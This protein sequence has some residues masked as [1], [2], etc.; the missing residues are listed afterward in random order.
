MSLKMESFVLDH[1]GIISTMYQELG[2]DKIIDE[3]LGVHGN[4]IVSSGQAVLSIICNMLNILQKPI[5]LTPQFMS[6]RSIDRLLEPRFAAHHFNDDLIGH[7]LDRLFDFGLEELFLKIASAAFSKYSEFLSDYLHADTTTIEVYGDYPEPGDGTI[8]LLRGFNKRRRGDFKQFVLELVTCNRLPVFLTTAD[9]N[10]S[11][12]VVFRNLLKQYGKQIH[13]VFTDDQK[14]FIFDSKFYVE[15]TIVNVSDSIFWI[16]RVPE[17]V[18]QAAKLVGDLSTDQFTACESEAL[19]GYSYYKSFSCFAETAQQWVVVFSQ[20]NYDK[21]EQILL[22]KLPQI[23][24]SLEKELWHFSTMQ[25]SVKTEAEEALRVL[26]EGPK[27]SY[28]KIGGYEWKLTT[29]RENGK[30][31]APQKGEVLLEFYSIINARLEIDQKKLD[32]A[33]IKKGRFVLASNRIDPEDFDWSVVEEF[34]HARIEAQDK[35]V[36]KELKRFS[37]LLFQSKQEG[38]AALLKKLKD[39]KSGIWQ[40]HSIDVNNLEDTAWQVVEKKASKKPGRA[41]QGEQLVPWFSL[42]LQ[43]AMVDESKVETYRKELK[44]RAMFDNPLEVEEQISAYKQQSKVERGFRFMKDGLFFASGVFLKKE[45][46]I[47]SVSMLLGVALLIYNLCELKLREAMKSAN[48]MFHDG[49]AKDTSN[50]TIRRVIVNFEAI[51]VSKIFY[52]GKLVNEEVVNLK[53]LHYKVLELLG[54][55][56]LDKYRDGVKKLEEMLIDGK[57]SEE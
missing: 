9:G 11:D 23:Q 21:E 25:F 54:P 24:E 38:K 46:R 36:K 43:Q 6:Q 40:F 53:E 50:P 33:L 15:E 47:M 35:Q 45:E 22:Q 39:Q 26:C 13:E 18:K 16:T 57:R 55:Q 56:Y 49:Y 5:Y 29:K 2:I 10:A 20:A 27:W 42:S 30:R 1:L 3:N 51:H 32:Q 17:T 12:S 34:I 31:G 28:H 37:K 4:Q 52:N 8:K 19:D 14:T 44:A 41:K 48:A 7:T